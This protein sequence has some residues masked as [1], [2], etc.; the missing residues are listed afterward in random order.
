LVLAFGLSWAWLIP[1]AVTHR[2]VVSGQGWPTHFPA[3]FGPA[4]AAF[5]VI[6]AMTGRAGVAGLLRRIVLWRVGWRWWLVALS[7]A[8]FLGLA[9]LA[10]SA[11]GS[12]PPR[13]ADFGAYSGMPTAGVLG[14]S[15]LVLVGA[16]GEEIGWRGF[17]LPALQHRFSSLVASIILAAVWAVWHL[18]MFF[19]IVTYRSFGVAQSVGFVFGLSCGAIVLT[20]LYN[21]SGGSILLVAVWHGLFNVVSGTAAATGVVAAVV[22]TLVMAQ[23]LLLV[24][25]DLWARHKGRPSPLAPAHRI[26]AGVEGS[27]APAR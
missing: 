11:A 18:P 17:A 25:L 10:S 14:V 24:G 3:L 2:A 21:R 7:P 16:L 8:G 12:E 9:L 13:V 5:L 19:V 15:L 20:W 6:A 4:A 22:S 26:G 23:A 1:M 27:H